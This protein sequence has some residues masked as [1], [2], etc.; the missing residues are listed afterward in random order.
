MGKDDQF[1]RECFEGVEY[2]RNSVRM[3]I[4]LIKFTD[5]NQ[6]TRCVRSK[7]LAERIAGKLAIQG[8]TVK[9]EEYDVLEGAPA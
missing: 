1:T 7:E 5:L 3:S 4:Y 8:C 9:V 2:T 6:K